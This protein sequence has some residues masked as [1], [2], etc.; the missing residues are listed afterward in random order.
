MAY[1]TS[2][3]AKTMIVRYRGLF[4]YDGL[5]NVMVQWIKARGY[6]FHER[7]YKHKV[8]TALGAEQEIEWDAEKKITDYYKFTIGIKWHLWEIT[9]VEVVKEGVKKVLTNARLEIKINGNLEIDWERRMGSSTF[10]TIVSDWYHKYIIRREIETIWYDTMYYR[11]Q[12]LHKLVKD[13]LDMEAK[14][15]AYEGYLGDNI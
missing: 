2:F 5:Y 14:G 10:W 11:L 4:D 8:P 15:Y 1:P 13:F 12:R 9:E 6:W 7:A 3:A